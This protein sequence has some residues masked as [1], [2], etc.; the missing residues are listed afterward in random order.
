MELHGLNPGVHQV[1]IAFE[2]SD[3]FNGATT[4]SVTIQNGHGRG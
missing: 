1:S 4:F 2:Y 3:G